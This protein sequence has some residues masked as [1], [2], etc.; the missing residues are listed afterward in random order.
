MNRKKDLFFSYFLSNYHLL[1]TTISY[2]RQE[3]IYVL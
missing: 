2:L 3:D 1:H